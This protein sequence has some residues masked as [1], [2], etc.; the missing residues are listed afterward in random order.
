MPGSFASSAV[1]SSITDN[2][3][4]D[5]K[6]EREREASG[7]LAQLFAIHLAGSPLGIAHCGDDQILYHFSVGSGEDA[8]V[9]LDAA[10]L[11]PSIDRCLDHAATGRAGDCTLRQLG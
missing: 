9:D 5:R 8:G 11:P 10:N 1:S 6:L 2:C 3:V 7:G 4:S